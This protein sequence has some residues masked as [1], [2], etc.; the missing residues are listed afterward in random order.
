MVGEAAEHCVVLVFAQ[1]F[2]GAV[3][4]RRDVVPGRDEVAGGIP[5][6]G[7]VVVRALDD[8]EDLVPAELV[9][10][11][12]GA[13][14]M[15][16]DGDA[17]AVFV[18]H[19]RIVRGDEPLAGRR[20]ECSPEVVADEAFDLFGVRHQVVGRVAHQRDF[21]S[22]RVRTASPAHAMTT[23]PPTTMGQVSC[24]CRMS[25]AQRMLITGWASWTWL[26]CAIGPM[27]RPRYQAKKPRNMLTTAR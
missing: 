6:R 16:G 22:R 12:V 7:D 11:V 10:D 13:P 25:A 1:D 14:E 18:E 9:E 26:T 17:L 20:D 27:A 19:D 15:A 5:A 23:A 8:D 4:V 2:R 21:L 3:E 24:S